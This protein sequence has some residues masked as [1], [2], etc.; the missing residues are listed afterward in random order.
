MYVYTGKG[1]GFYE[2]IYEENSGKKDPL[3]LIGPGPMMSPCELSA[4]KL[5]RYLLASSFRVRTV[6]SDGT[7]LHGFS[8]PSSKRVQLPWRDS[9]RP[10]DRPTSFRRNE[11]HTKNKIRTRRIIKGEHSQGVCC[12][13]LFLHTGATRK[14]CTSNANYRFY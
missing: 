3:P 6:Q 14:R 9:A 1:R 8:F 11:N 13:S 5:P 2:R 4:T 10:T 7:T 12:S